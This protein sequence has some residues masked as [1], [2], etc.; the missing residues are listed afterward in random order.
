MITSKAG[1]ELIKYFEG[2]RTKAYQDSVGVWTIGYGHT[3]DV[4]QGQVI[5]EQEAEA[6]LVADLKHFEN[7]VTQE[8]KRC[9]YVF[10]QNEFD[11]LVSFTF[12]LGGKNLRTLLHDGNRTK[13]QICKAIALYNRAGGQVLKGLTRRRGAEQK[14]YKGESWQ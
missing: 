10:N 4:K 9:N 11:A 13:E 14:L 6:L 12:N 7:V 2:L 5:T 8:E 3:H 1:I